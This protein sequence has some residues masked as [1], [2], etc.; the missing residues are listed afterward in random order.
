MAEKRRGP[1]DLEARL[2]GSHP[3]RLLLGIDTEADDQWSAEG[4]RR[5]DVRNAERLPALQSLCDRFGVRPTYFVTWEMATQEP[6]R[7]ILRDLATGGRSEIGAHLHPWSMPARRALDPAAHTYPHNLPV[8]EL[9]SQLAELTEVIEAQLG[10]RPRS[11]RAGRNGFDHHAL[12]ILEKLSYAVDSSVDPLFNER[13]KGGMCF[14]GAAVAPYRPDARDVRWPGQ[15]TVLEI[16]ISAGLI[17]ALGRRAEAL[18]ASLP[19]L[20]Y[21]GLLRRLGVRGAWLRPS[22]SSLTDMCRL[23]DRLATH[24]GVL[25]AAFHSSELL[26]GGS[27]YSPDEASVTRILDSLA[28]LFE[29]ACDRLGAVGC[30]Y[31]DYASAQRRLP[32]AGGRD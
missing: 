25:N 22:Y 28:R 14:A 10:T 5:L 3:T 16:P 6:A 7:S 20:P 21:R 32:Q 19:P 26:P 9:E 8:E 17:P 29:H 24:V 15:S 27:P 12:P 23:A 11:Y 31:S 18:F 30:T 1:D 13:R 4:R 2:G